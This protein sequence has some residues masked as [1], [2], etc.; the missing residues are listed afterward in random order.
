MINWTQP[1]GDSRW[2]RSEP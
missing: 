2:R 1:R